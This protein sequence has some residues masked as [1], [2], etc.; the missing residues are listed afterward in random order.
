MSQPTPVEKLL[1]PEGCEDLPRMLADLTVEFASSFDIDETLRNALDRFIAYLQAEAGS[2]FLLEEDGQALVCRECA[3]PVDVAGVKL[4]P[5]EGIVGKTVQ[6]RQAQIVR[7]AARD[8]AFSGTVDAD[9]G[10]VTRSILCAPLL[11][12][13]QCIGALELINKRIGDGLFDE[14]DVNLVTAIAAAAALA[15]HNARMAA[16]LVEQERVRRELELARQI[17]ESLLP[18]AQGAGIPVFGLNIPAREVSGDFY[19]FIELADGRIYFSLADVSGKGM[20]AAL[21]MAKTSSL[22]RCLAKSSS[23]IG[24]L[25]EQVN[26][27][28]CETA[29]MGMFVTIVAGYIDPSHGTLTLANAGHQPVLVRDRRGSFEEI[30]ASAPPLGVLPDIDY[31]VTTVPLNDIVMFIYTDGVTESESTDGVQLGVDGLQ[32]LILDTDT[33]PATGR[34]R[35]IVDA[36][37]RGGF[38]SHDDITLMMIDAAGPRTAGV[39]LAI[40]FQAAPAQL[41]MVRERVKAAVDPLALDGKLVSDLVIAINEACMNI[42]QHAYRG[43]P[44]GEIDLEIINNGNELTVTIRDFAAPIDLGAVKPRNIE[45][46]RPGGLGVHFIRELMDECNYEHGADRCGNILRMKKRID[47]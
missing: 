9:T 3:G 47:G 19:D 41:R 42:I 4:R 30:A 35:A 38:Q 27:E 40:R 26:N 39:L 37:H 20:N 33:Y 32:S 11:V 8:P 25:L 7:D 16:L 46:I 12:R 14:R 36:L 31:T 43:D 23:D 13:D 5:D 17:Q 21:L 44:L 24:T 6:L 15:I 18:A 34:L 1:E 22:L 2:I 28:I 45:D 29:S 10:F